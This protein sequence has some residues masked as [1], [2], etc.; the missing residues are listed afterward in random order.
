MFRRGG[1]EGWVVG[2]CGRGPW[3]LKETGVEVA[4]QVLSNAVGFDLYNID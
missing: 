4:V 3:I 2:E 1:G